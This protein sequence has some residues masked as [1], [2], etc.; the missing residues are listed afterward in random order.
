MSKNKGKIL[1]V[2]DNKEL[3]TAL[4]MFLKQHFTEVQTERN[5]NKIPSLIREETF[6]IILLDMNFSAGVS[7]G[8]EGIFWMREILKIDPD[9]TI[10][11]ITAYGDV[12]LAV[13]SMK[14]GATD[15]IQKSWDEDKMLSTILSAYKLRKSKLEIKKLK[16]RQSH[17]TEELGKLPESCICHSEPMQKIY[18]L[19]DKVAGTDANILLTGEN[20]TGKEIIARQIHT[21]SSR[22]E[23]AFI[24]VDLGAIHENLFESEL[25]GHM[26]G[27]FTDAKTD[28]PGKFEIASGGTIFLDEIGN[29]PFNLQPKLLS[30]LQNRVVYRLGS[31]QSVPVDIHVISATNQP[32]LDMIENNRFREDLLYRLNTIQIDLPPL[33]ERPEDVETLAK[34]F[35]KKYCVK[36]HKELSIP[37]STITKMKDYTWPGNIRELQHSIEKAVILSDDKEI[38]SKLLIPAEKAREMSRKKTFNLEENE[39]QIIQHALNQFRGNISLAAEKLGINRSTLYAKIKKYDIQ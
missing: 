38:N 16:N 35:L 8:N 20:G 31:N 6:D 15:F 24:K 10:I 14:E 9:A 36:Y 23:Q 26:K 29:L 25:F 32:L 7:T 28:K 19:I 18:R 5:P 1:I 33:R 27:A 13:K 4:S 17:L 39:K 30:V 12:D 11:F 37:H 34:Y 2:D 21:K 22:F 3:L